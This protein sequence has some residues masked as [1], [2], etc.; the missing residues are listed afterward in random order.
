MAKPGCSWARCVL[1]S[2]WL[3]MPVSGLT[4]PK[5]RGAETFWE[6]VTNGGERIVHP[7]ITQAIL[8]VG[9]DFLGGQGNDVGDLQQTY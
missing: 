4:V 2:S 8:F 9:L 5:K 7:R 3:E 1:K 6:T